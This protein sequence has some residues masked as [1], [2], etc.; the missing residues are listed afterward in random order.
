MTVGGGL[1]KTESCP[2]V[3][4]ARGR[5][6]PVPILEAPLFVF[7]VELAGLYLEISSLNASVFNEEGGHVVVLPELLGG[8]LD[9]S[10]NL[11]VTTLL[12]APQAFEHPVEY[13]GTL[14]F[15][16][17]L[18]FRVALILSQRREGDDLHAPEEARIGVCYSRQFVHGPTNPRLRVAPYF[19]E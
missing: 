9:A 14:G 2:V 7:G 11:E 8:I 4:Q 19:S 13:P 3:S 17:M 12:E 1:L 10:G 6:R 16:G 15:D 18:D 5:H